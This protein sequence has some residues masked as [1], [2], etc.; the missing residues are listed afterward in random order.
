MY[1]ILFLSIICYKRILK[2]LKVFNSLFNFVTFYIDFNHS[3]KYFLL[4]DIKRFNIF[5]RFKLISN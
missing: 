4:E 1:N 3:L 2:Q 5:L